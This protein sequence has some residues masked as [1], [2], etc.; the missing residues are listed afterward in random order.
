MALYAYARL[1]DEAGD[2][3]SGDRLAL[4][5]AIEEDLDAAVSGAPRHPV[6]TRLAPVIRRHGLPRDALGRLIEANRFDQ[7]G[8]TIADEEA[9]RAY[10]RL[11]ANP[12]GELVLHLFGQATPSRVARSDAVCTALQVLEHCQDVREDAEAGRVYLPKDE[13]DAEGI[14]RDELLAASAS[15][16]LR[17]VVAR[18]VGRSREDL[19]EGRSLVR[20]LRGAARF[21]VAGF[22]GGGFATCRAFE[23]A[24]YDPLRHVVKASRRRQLLEGVRVLLGRGR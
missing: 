11:S 18:Q 3:A 8:E 15:S 23:D 14:G 4:L 10:C 5:D 7:R 22:V 19:R 16:G 24:G 12:V 13:L 17:R 2:A 21:A 6:L 9:L 20:E 1:V